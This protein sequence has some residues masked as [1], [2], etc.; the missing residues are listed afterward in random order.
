VSGAYAAALR[1]PT[2]AP[3]ERRLVAGAL[4]TALLV[5]CP[6]IA[7]F[8]LALFPSDNIWPHLV[9]TVLPGYVATTLQ[10]IAGVGA[11]TFLLGAATA[12]TVTMYDFPGRRLFE[13]LLLVPLAMPTY[14]IAYSYVDLFAYYGPVQEMLREA[15]GFTSARDYWFPEIRSLGGAI[16]VM[17]FVLYPYVYMTARAS[18]HLQSLSLI[19]ACRT[20]GR[21]MRAAFLSVALPLARPAIV[22]GVVLAMMECLNDL[23]AVQHFG[24]NT[25][26]AGIYATWLQKNNLAGAAQIATVMLVFVFVLILLERWARRG[27]RFHQIGSR[28]H[29]PARI[30]LTGA[31]G[32][33]AAALCAAPVIV[34][35]VVPVAVLVRFA[36]ARAAGQDFVRFA[37]QAANSL[38]LA[39]L[40]A[41]AAVAIGLFLTHAARTSR[42]TPVRIATIAGSVGY[43]VPGAVLAIGILV[44][45][46]RIDNAVD[47]LARDLLGLS[48]GL[49]LTGTMASIVIA[50]VVRFMAVAYGAIDAGYGRL[51]PSLQMAAR[52][53]GRTP[54][55]A[56]REVQLPLMKPAIVAAALLVFVDSMKEL[57]ATLL[58]RPFDFD[59]LA[60]QVYT[61]AS[62]AMV[63]EAAFP[64][65]AIVAVGIVPVLALNRTLVLSA[66]GVAQVQEVRLAG[67]SRVARTASGDDRAPV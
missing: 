10:L 16:V 35:F 37:E 1:R 52:S 42:V 48:T 17:A 19:E 60:T 24:V 58:L 34:G 50:Y 29:P 20:L 64:A 11:I 49:L 36:L 21:P 63:E 4:A 7:I 27:R 26:T 62:L 5:G 33:G 12:W 44:P 3:G 45:L 18:F 54:F 31:A 67:A 8:V 22:I 51:S 61:F 9:A 53:L 32:W 15:L 55:Q 65:L 13:V 14:I 25:L 6:V 56:L 57:P 40:A 28:S 2:R 38:I 66:A 47:A 39:S 46:A 43:A 23:G 59:T 41:A 30:R